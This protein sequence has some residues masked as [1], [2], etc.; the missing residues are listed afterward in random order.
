MIFFCLDAPTHQQ[1]DNDIAR[2]PIQGVDPG[3]T[4]TYRPSTQLSEP[5]ILLISLYLFYLL[6]Y[7]TFIFEDFIFYVYI[8]FYV[9]IWHI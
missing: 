2:Q 1:R 9:L 5:Q 3:D 8:I 7:F 4:C 6:F